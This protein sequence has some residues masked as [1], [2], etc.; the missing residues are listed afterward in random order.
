[1]SGL[2]LGGAAALVPAEAS[3]CGGFFCDGG[4]QPMAVDQTGEDILFIANGETVEV[5]IRIQYM[6]DPENFAWVIPVLSVPTDFN[7]GSE[8]F[9]DNIKNAS[10]PTYGITTQRDDCSLPD[11]GESSDTGA[12]TAGSTSG[13]SDGGFDTDGEDPGPTI[14]AMETV[15]AFEITVLGD[16]DVQEVMTWLN[17]NGYQQDPAAEPILAEYIAEGHLF[18]AIKLNGGAGLDELHPIALTFD[19]SEPCVP[20]R[21]TRI[22]ATDDMDVRA[23]FLGDGR[24]VPKTYRH[25]LVNPLKI[26]W[27]N[28][29]ANYKEV[30]TRA[31][32]AEHADGR[33][34]VTEYAGSSD[35]VGRGGLDDPN[36]NADAFVA[37][38]AVDAPGQLL[39]QGLVVCGWDPN[40]GF[41]TC[42]GVHPMVDPLL[43]QFLPVPDG[44]DP[45]E[46]YNNTS[47]YEGLID[48]TAWDGAAFATLLGERVIEPGR[49]ASALL[50][51][52]P[53][54]TRMYTTISP[55]EMLEDPMFHENADLEEVAAS[56]TGTNRILCSGDSVWTLPDGREVFVPVGGTWPDIGGEKWWE[57]EVQETP[58]IGPE[59]VLVNNTDAI[60][61]AL[62]DH[63]AMH[64]WDG[65]PEVPGG[66]TDGGSGTDGSDSAGGSGSDPE[67]AQGCGC[68]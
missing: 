57:E 29:P 65:A 60:N 62:A 39:L 35:I 26:D 59:I 53:Y 14:Y 52:Y 11:A 23:F 19:H 1:M 32:D 61:Q 27:I 37:M 54:L 49:H 41:E 56:R 55:H 66:G 30:I 17:D 8:A 33:A 21:L 10:V 46:F 18:A 36:W 22:A 50:D 64:G 28:Q 13:T 9:F 20:L 16:G 34:F 58:A 45:F 4:P 44:V 6:G 68:A 67:S 43:A 51:Q 31:V 3:A 48:Q 24:V 7:V 42:A 12:A 40:T 5:H 15:G 47:A 2:A 63:N 38:Q 25:V